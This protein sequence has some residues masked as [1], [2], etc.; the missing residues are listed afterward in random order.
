MNEWTI[1]EHWMTRDAKFGTTHIN[2][3]RLE[4]HDSMT[5]ESTLHMQ[6]TMNIEVWDQTTR[7]VLRKNK[8]L[9]IEIQDWTSTCDYKF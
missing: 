8:A 1:D 7:W 5:Q 3:L 9:N 4:H 6:T 2:S